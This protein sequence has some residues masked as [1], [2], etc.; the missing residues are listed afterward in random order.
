MW[1]EAGM[2]GKGTS[3]GGRAE[4]LIS[5]TWLTQSQWQADGCTLNTTFFFFFGPAGSQCLLGRQK[6]CTFVFF[7][8]SECVSGEETYKGKNLDLNVI[9]I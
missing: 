2:G 4:V 9:R 6:A 8:S 5:F 3:P 7:S 1:K